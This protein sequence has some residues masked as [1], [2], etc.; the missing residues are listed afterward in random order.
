[1]AEAGTPALAFDESMALEQIVRSTS[2]W[3]FPAWV[4]LLED[5]QKLPS[6]P[7][8]MEAPQLEESDQN[9]LGRLVWAAKGSV[10]PIFESCPPLLLEPVEPLVARLPAD[11]VMSAEFG[12]AGI[13]P[14][15]GIGNESSSHV[16]G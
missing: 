9:F 12:V 7:G 1:M 2:S 11:A 14:V 5:S 15:E 3:Q 13:A 8:R 10:G 4:T 6:A 16:H